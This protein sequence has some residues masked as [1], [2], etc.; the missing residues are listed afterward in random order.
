VASDNPHAGKQSW[1]RRLFR[2]NNPEKLPARMVVRL[3]VESVTGS[4]TPIHTE[5]PVRSPGSNSD[6]TGL[7][8]A[9]GK[10]RRVPELT[11]I[12]TVK[13]GGP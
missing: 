1:I 6:K 3:T 11:S 8:L 10:D 2:K 9:P 5:N 4:G 13:R 7:V 12:Q